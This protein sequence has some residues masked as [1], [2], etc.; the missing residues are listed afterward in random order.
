[1]K[2]HFA[3]LVFLG[4]I[5]AAR[6][7][8]AAETGVTDKEIL[9]GSCSDLSTDAQKV[10]SKIRLQGAKAYLEH[11]NDQGGVHGRRIKVLEEDDAYDPN[12]AILCFNKLL[13]AHSFIGAFFIGGPGAAKYAALAE[14][15]KIPIVGLVAGSKFLYSPVKKYVFTVRGS[16]ENMLD[17][18]AGKL[19]D[20]GARRVAIIFQEDAFGAGTL[21]ALR[22]VLRKHS[23]ELVASAGVPHASDDVDVAMK[24][25]EDS[26]PDIVVMAL[27][28]APGA[29]VLKKSRDD[30]FSPIF[31]SVSNN[32]ELFKLSGTAIN[33]TI[34]PEVVP[35]PARTDLPS[36][37]LYTKLLKERF[38]GSA[39]NATGVEGFAEAMVIVEGLRKAGPS[40]TR[41]KFIA[42]LESMSDVDLGF[43]PE[44]R[45]SY[46]PADHSAFSSIYPT[47]V[48]DGKAVPIDDW[49][50]L[51]AGRR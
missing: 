33:G 25:V 27:I 14:S 12:Q 45:V 22:T 23:A 31:I 43:G 29:T 1:M 48:K 36:I 35:L 42:A 5:L 28:G 50:K 13:E 39:P 49:N 15:K 11:V 8:A 41:E 9:I 16:Y 17:G 51:T 7:P 4:L 20:L 10:R 21:E 6:S 34:L 40:P 47:V 38:P 2:N 44:F 3:P 24:I 18:T 32:P 37:A 26:K 19:M 30:A 46:G